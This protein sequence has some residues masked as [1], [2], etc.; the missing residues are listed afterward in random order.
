MLLETYY[1]FKIQVETNY[2]GRVLSYIQKL[3]GTFKPIEIIENKVIIR[4]NELVVTFMTYS[5][6]L[7]SFTKGKGSISLFFSGYDKCNNKEEI[8]KRIGYD[9]N[10]DIEYTSSSIFCSKGQGYI[11]EGKDVKEHMHC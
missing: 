7:I 9:K 2:I 10:L 11:V 5:I 8:I 6:E 1:N 4:G 3:N